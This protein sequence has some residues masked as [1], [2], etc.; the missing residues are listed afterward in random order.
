MA[1]ESCSVQHTHAVGGAK[2]ALGARHAGERLETRKLTLLRA[3]VDGRRAVARAKVQEPVTNMY[4]YMEMRR[5][6]VCAFFIKEEFTD[7]LNF[8]VVGTYIG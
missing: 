1:S 7:Q 4:E 2:P 5:L 8:N 6:N 3:Q